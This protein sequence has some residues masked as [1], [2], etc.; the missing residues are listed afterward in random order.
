MRQ[1]RLLCILSV[2]FT[3][4]PQISFAAYTSVFE[5]KNYDITINVRCS[6]GNVSC[7]D[8]VFT[9]L[10]K[11]KQT[12]LVMKG[13]TLNRDCITG[14]CDFYGYEFKNKGRI[15]KIYQYG[16]LDISKKGKLISSESGVFRY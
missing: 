5:T 2:I 12:S 1:K 15:Y 10:N 6:E 8:V 4:P 9:L 13:K 16:I 7:D 14:S 11:Q 3:V